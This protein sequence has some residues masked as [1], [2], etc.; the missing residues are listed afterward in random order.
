M[1]TN[2][3]KRIN[4]KLILII[5]K[6][7]TNKTTQEHNDGRIDPI[8]LQQSIRLDMK[9]LRISEIAENIISIKSRCKI[10]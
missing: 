1:I 10:R 4:A 5:G 9:D 2:I 3:L 6:I 8:Q 7:S